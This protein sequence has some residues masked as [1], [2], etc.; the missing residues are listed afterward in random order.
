MPAAENHSHSDRPPRSGN[1]PS[2]GTPI[3]PIANT[4]LAET[5][6]HGGR[7]Y[8]LMIDS[9]RDYAI[10]ML[11]PNGHVASWNQGA[12]RM[13]GYSSDE[14]VGQ[15]F[16]VFYPR[17]EIDRGHPQHELEIAARE[18]T[19]EE[20]AYRLR[21]DGSVFWASVLIT[22]VRDDNDNLIGFAK[23]TRDL[24]E[25]R[26]AEQRALADAQAGGPALGVCP[27]P[28]VTCP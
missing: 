7:I 18:G 21:K 17:E 11:D 27:A 25:R 8:Q 16:S 4:R 15:H 12:E 26:N 10:F 6:K 28:L 3:I 20:D 1:T 2:E 13:K 5:I 9:V 22:A 14:I 19:F 23:V 24:T